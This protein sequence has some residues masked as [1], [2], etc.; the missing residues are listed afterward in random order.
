[1]YSN[2]YLLSRLKFIDQNSHW[3][4]ILS[5]KILSD[6]IIKLIVFASEFCFTCIVLH[7]LDGIM[8]VVISRKEAKCI[9]CNQKPKVIC[10][11]LW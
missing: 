7:F 4:S 6:T 11:L 9:L 2:S 10:V 5:F 1:M 8:T 3:L